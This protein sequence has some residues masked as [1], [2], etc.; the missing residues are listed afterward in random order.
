M[1]ARLF[2]R[3]AAIVFV[4]FAAGH[5]FG[6][7]SLKAPT[8][9]AEAVRIAM[10]RAQFHNGLSFGG[11]YVGL[12]LYVS[13]YL[14]FSAFL[15]WHLGNLAATMPKAIS[16]IGWSFFALQLASVAL[17]CI[18]FG[19]PPAVFSGLVALCLGTAAWFSR[20]APIPA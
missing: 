13:L 16:S 12:G 15:A 14:L 6:F 4:L 8:A 3:I 5:T 1:T 17:S 18:F 20:Q 2:Y 19:T 10:D 7:L 11:F 9:E